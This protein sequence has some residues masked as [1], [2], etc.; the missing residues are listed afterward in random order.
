[1][2]YTDKK[3]IA[4]KIKEILDKHE[5]TDTMINYLA[6]Q[7]NDILNTEHGQLRRVLDDCKG[8]SELL[9]EG[10][11]SV[12]ELINAYNLNE[13]K[14]KKAIDAYETAKQ[15]LSQPTDDVYAIIDEYVE[16]YRDY[17]DMIVDLYSYRAL[18]DLMCRNFIKEHLK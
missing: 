12:E 1:M 9:Q 16:A 7:Q 18:I 3:E 14:L 2:S 6:K 8:E 13:L 4:K 17:L 10:G 15:N 5:T 11:W